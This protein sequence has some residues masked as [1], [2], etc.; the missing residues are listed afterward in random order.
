RRGS[1]WSEAP[2]LGGARDSRER[3]SPCCLRRRLDHAS[4][5]EPR[6]VVHDVKEGR[7][8]AFA[9][10]GY[11]LSKEVARAVDSRVRSLFAL[12]GERLVTAFKPHPRRT[13][14][15]P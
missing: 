9:R 5:T 15:G 4:A 2:R 13:W 6:H 3:R 11:A 8:L 12:S 1:A 10:V 7:C 14:R